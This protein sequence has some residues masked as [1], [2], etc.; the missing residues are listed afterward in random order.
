MHTYRT[1]PVR[2]FAGFYIRMSLGPVSIFIE[3][4]KR[5]QDNVLQNPCLFTICCFDKFALAN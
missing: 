3:L 2:Q 5:F 1:W 4:Y